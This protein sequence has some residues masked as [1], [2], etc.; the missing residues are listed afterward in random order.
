MWSSTIEIELYQA[1]ATNSRIQFYCHGRHRLCLSLGKRHL[2]QSELVR[3]DASIPEE[4][5]VDLHCC[6]LPGGF[7]NRFRPESEVIGAKAENTL[8]ED[9]PEFRVSAGAGTLFLLA[10]DFVPAA[11]S[12]LSGCI[13]PSLAARRAAKCFS[14]SIFLMRLMALR[15]FLRFSS[16]SSKSLVK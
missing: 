13:L 1:N 12:G 2:V 15:P 9:G 11:P 4:H 5:R 6:R 16:Y 8:A 7:S 14:T 3:Q 10:A